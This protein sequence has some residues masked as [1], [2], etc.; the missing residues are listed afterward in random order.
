MTGRLRVVPSKAGHCSTQ[1]IMFPNTA[2]TDK[3]P[4]GLH[5]TV[6]FST[7]FV[8]CME[9]EN[10][11]KPVRS[12]PPK[13]EKGTKKTYKLLGKKWLLF[14]ISSCSC[15]FPRHFSSLYTATLSIQ[16]LQKPLQSIKTV[17]QK[18][19]LNLNA[20]KHNHNNEKFGSSWIRTWWCLR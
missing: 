11:T 12:L 7:F 3:H 2:D 18:K 15:L 6:R 14:R 8:L 13:Y 1:H 9:K 4:P 17:L 10:Q 5:L 16:T 20:T 19:I